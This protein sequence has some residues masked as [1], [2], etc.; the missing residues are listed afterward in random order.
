MNDNNICVVANAVVSPITL[1]GTKNIITLS[2]NFESINWIFAL[3]SEFLIY[4]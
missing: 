4:N 3:F 1:V 2:L